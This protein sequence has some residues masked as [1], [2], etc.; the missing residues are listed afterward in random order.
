MNYSSRVALLGGVID[1]AGTFPP[2]ALRLADALK[3]A[4]SFRRAGKHPWLMGRIALPVADIKK[5]TAKW[6][7]DSGA[8]GA[9]WIFTALG[10]AA[11][12][13]AAADL[14]RAVDWD[15]R[16][17]RHYLA[18]QS[19][20]SLRMLIAGY[21]LKLPPESDREVIR[22]Y[23]RPV[24][25]RFTTLGMGTLPYFEVSLDADWRHRLE[26]VADSL[27]HWSED[28]PEG[29]IPGIKIR[30]GGQSVPAAEQVAEV[31]TAC[32][33]RGL[34]FKATQGLHEA[35]THGTHLGF[36]NLFASLTLASVLGEEKF[37]KEM[38]ANCLKASSAKDFTFATE[39]FAWREFRLTS[40]EVE[41]GRRRHAGTFGSCSLDEP[42]ESLAKTFLEKK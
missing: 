2:A 24:L 5:L 3:R 18:R 10:G 13:P 41:T 22:E 28:A 31:I 40:D 37:G 9:P 29:L 36:V 23:I 4:A 15:L 20:G 39:T 11:A 16:E 21:E 8:D 30:T 32:V 35:V 1:Y 26:S 42:D 33:S 27:A 7:Y 17:L 34:R 12:G 6:L 38:V 19:E 14:V 25:D